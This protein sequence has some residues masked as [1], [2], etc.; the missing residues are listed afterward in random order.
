VPPIYPNFSQKCV[1]CH[2]REVEVAFIGCGH[3]VTCGDCGRMCLYGTH[4]SE[5]EEC[6][7]SF[8]IKIRNL[9]ILFFMFFFIFF[10]YTKVLDCAQYA[11]DQLKY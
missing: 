1:V 10:I 4:N 5:R 6:L 7:I 11:E 9:H 2:E 8:N 3:A